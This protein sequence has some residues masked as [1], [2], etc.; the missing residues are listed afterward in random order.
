MHENE[1]A[2]SE[3]VDGTSAGAYP[4]S[5][6][7]LRATTLI[8]QDADFAA[9]HVLIEEA[10]NDRWH[11]LY[12]SVTYGPEADFRSIPINLEESRYGSLCAIR[13]RIT[14][15]TAKQLVAAAASGTTRIDVFDIEFTVDEVVEG[16]R[17]TERWNR[18]DPGPLHGASSWRRER[19]GIRKVLSD[20]EL[21]EESV[22]DIAERL[23]FLN[24][25]RWQGI[26]LLRHPE[27]LGD[28]DEVWPSP[29]VF[30][31]RRAGDGSGIVVEL[32]D[33][34]LGVDPGLLSMT[35]TA[36]K[37]GMICRT[38]SEAGAFPKL[39][40]DADCTDLRLFVDGI[41][42][43]QSSGCFVNTVQ[44][45]IAVGPALVL[46][47]PAYRS[48]RTL[49]VAVGAS[50]V[51]TTTVGRPT[52]VSIRAIAWEIGRRFREERIPD[53]SENFYDITVNPSAA[54]E[55]FEDLGKLGSAQRGGMMAVV[56]PF[57]LDAQALFSIIAAALPQM[58]PERLRVYTEFKRHELIKVRKPWF[59]SSLGFLRRRKANVP[60]SNRDRN[61]AEF[62]RV[63][64]QVANVT[65]VPIEVFQADRLHDR[66]IL[67]KDRIWHVGPSFNTLGQEV[68]AIVEMRDTRT[69]AKVRAYLQRQPSEPVWTTT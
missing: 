45:T 47:G 32:T 18:L 8:E 57:A 68:A 41:V 63:A 22:Y 56:D 53:D 69:K 61:Q 16:F 55:A 1:N 3:G 14:I 42:M 6:D 36:Y 60:V 31:E 44:N 13:Q 37:N 4:A 46:Q 62:F 39:L 33:D 29:V 34:R 30:H 12:M 51:S 48:R 43:D 59:L 7:F 27:K 2:N 64:Q 9:L 50:N 19:I 25:A 26:P 24:Q 21:S 5:S 28:I 23:S 65:K 11:N 52:P 15:A 54:T 49:D 10:S 67:L 35:G 58:T 38:V 40:P 17:P 20:V 66:F